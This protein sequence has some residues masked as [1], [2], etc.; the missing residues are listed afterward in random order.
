MRSDANNLVNTSQAVKFDTCWLFD[1]IWLWTMPKQ[2]SKRCTMLPERFFVSDF[3]EEIEV[4]LTL[5]NGLYHPEA[6][7]LCGIANSVITLFNCLLAWSSS[8]KRFSFIFQV[9]HVRACC[10]DVCR[11]KNG[12]HAP[13]CFNC[14]KTGSCCWAFWP[15]IGSKNEISAP[16][17]CS[18]CKLVSWTEA[19]WIRLR[20]VWNSWMVMTGCN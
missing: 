15:E 8:M 2:R 10:N 4:V 9:F 12:R 11:R 19:D 7:S 3:L 6:V 1:T 16:A 13:L 18:S 17:S 14:S 20:L 5:A